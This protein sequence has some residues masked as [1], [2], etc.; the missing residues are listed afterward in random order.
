RRV[1]SRLFHPPAH[2]TLPYTI[3][4]I[5][6]LCYPQHKHEDGAPATA[7]A[8]EGTRG[9]SAT[10]FATTPA[11][12]PPLKWAGGKRW[13]VPNLLPIWQQHAWRRLVEPLCGGLAVALGL[14]P[15]RAL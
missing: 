2:P 10:S 7:R 9:M 13:L 14:R 6:Q 11:L 5:A 8:N 4:Q 3:A 1:G 15:D 12:K